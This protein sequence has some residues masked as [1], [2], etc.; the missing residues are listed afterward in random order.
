LAASARAGAH[1]ARWLR[2]RGALTELVA[3]LPEGA[4]GFR[5]WSEAMTTAA[6]IQHIALATDRF[7]GA[8]RD[9]ALPPPPAVRPAPPATIAEARAL[10]EEKTAEDRRILEGL[11]DA[12]LDARL[13]FGPMGDVPGD[14]LLTLAIDHEIHHK[15]QLWTYAR[16][17]G[18]AP[19]SF[20]RRE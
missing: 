15:G 7:F 10:L 16:M 6:L 3:Q 13:A 8:V 14:A 5:P 19:P 2:H 17:C 20:V 4:A 11:A 1:L 18:V 9:G 12:R